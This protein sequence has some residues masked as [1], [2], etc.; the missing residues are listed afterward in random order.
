MRDRAQIGL[1]CYHNTYLNVSLTGQA[2]GNLT[3]YNNSN[4]NVYITENG[5]AIINA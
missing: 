2:S 1:Q 5:K 3:F 4:A